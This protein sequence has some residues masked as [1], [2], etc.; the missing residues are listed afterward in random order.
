TSNDECWGDSYCAEGR[1]VPYGVPAGHDHDEACQ[2][3]ID[4]EA[5]VPEVQCRWTGPPAEDARPDAVHVMATPIVVDLDLD[6]DPTTLAPSIVFASFPTAGSYRSPGVLRIIDGAG[7]TQQ[8]SFPDPADAVMS[9]APVAAGDLD[10]D[11]RAE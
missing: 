3:A 1:C 6:H 10:G 7:C 8:F 4:I 5:L 11:G 2:R 9:P